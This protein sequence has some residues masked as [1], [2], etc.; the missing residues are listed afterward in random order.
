MK[1]LTLTGAKCNVAK[2]VNS[3]VILCCFFFHMGGRL[4]TQNMIGSR[5]DLTGK[6]ESIY[7]AVAIVIIS[8]FENALCNDFRVDKDY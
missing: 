2:V 4:S 7:N 1:V 6:L 5:I 3:S 8:D